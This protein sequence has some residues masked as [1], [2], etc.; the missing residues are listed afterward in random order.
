MNCWIDKLLISSDGDG[1]QVDA[2]RQGIGDFLGLT[3]RFDR[4]R[5]L[6]IQ[7]HAAA[8]SSA[9]TLFIIAPNDEPTPYFHSWFRIRSTAV[10]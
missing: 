8:I 5:Q 2:R 3:D 10:T 7:P 9:I 1:E 6:L 4:Q